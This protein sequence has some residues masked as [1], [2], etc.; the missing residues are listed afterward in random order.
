MLSQ[1]WAG[2]RSIVVL[3]SV[4]AD[5]LQ[6]QAVIPRLLTLHQVYLVE[7]VPTNNNAF[8]GLSTRCLLTR[9]HYLSDKRKCL[10]PSV[11]LTL[12]NP[13]AAIPDWSAGQCA[14]LVTT[15]NTGFGQLVQGAQQ[16]RQ[17]S[18]LS[19]HSGQILLLSCFF[20][21]FRHCYHSDNAIRK[22]LSYFYV[23]SSRKDCFN[24]SWKVTNA[25]LSCFSHI[26]KTHS[27]SKMADSFQQAR[28]FGKVEEIRSELLDSF[29]R[30]FSHSAHLG[31]FRGKQLSR[32]VLPSF[33]IYPIVI[34]DRHTSRVTVYSQY[35]PSPGTLVGR[36]GSL[37]PATRG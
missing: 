1:R 21:Q 20:I 3:S 26:T 28:M 35:L 37:H 10:C 34:R 13:Y 15:T 8:N 9:E 12:N 19:S 36:E 22:T 33:T 32:V 29:R 14:H 2:I 25:Y 11:A 5:G 30:I 17:D 23:F 18:H 7:V 24:N 27:C 31:Q 16:P 6:T 4:D